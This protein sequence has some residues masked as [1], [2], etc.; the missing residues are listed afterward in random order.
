M[1]EISITILGLLQGIFAMLNKRINW[2]FYAAQ[3]ALL[4]VF[5]WIAHLYGDTFQNFCYFFICIV[6]Y[7]MWKKDLIADKI[8]VLSFSNRIIWLLLTLTITISGGLL[9]S[10]T[11][12]PL[13]YVDSFTSTTT[14]VG[15]LLMMEH[16]LETWIVWFFNDIAYMYQYFNLPDQALY[17]FALYC[18]W[19]IMAVISF[20]NWAKIYKNEKNNPNVAFS[21][22]SEF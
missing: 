16:K 6:G 18:I 5:S 3:M 21:T 9:L 19:T 10:N 4:T 17:L 13:P 8:T 20:I 15:I 2:I 11:D 14:M 22:V 12:D 1:L 7:F